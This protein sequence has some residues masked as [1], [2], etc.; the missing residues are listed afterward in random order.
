M[1]N[2]SHVDGNTSTAFLSDQ[3][4]LSKGSEQPSSSYQCALL[5]AAIETGLIIVGLLFV[6]L[7]LPR[8]IGR[9]WHISL[10]M[11]YYAFYSTHIF[12]TTL[13]IP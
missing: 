4:A 11:I 9:R 12:I 7:L 2:V 5:Q 3:E 10:S 1:N 6:A 8:Q 13:G